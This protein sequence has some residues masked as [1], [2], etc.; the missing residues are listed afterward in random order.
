MKAL[1]KT[2]LLAAVGVALAVSILTGLYPENCSSC[3]I[4]SLLVSSISFS[5]AGMAFYSVLALLILL[6]RTWPAVLPML[7]FAAG[8]HG[9]LLFTLYENEH[10]CWLCVAAGASIGAAF[11]FQALRQPEE[12]TVMVLWLAIGLVT[13]KGVIEAGEFYDEQQKSAAIHTATQDAKAHVEMVKGKASMVIY[14]L[15]GCHNCERFETE[16]LPRIQAEFG[17]SV[18]LQHRDPPPYLPA[19]SIFIFPGPSLFL[20][21]PPQDEL[22][23]TLQEAVQASRTTESG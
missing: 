14:S 3:L 21:L 2:V 11:V 13:S 16:Q 18:T 23:E 22:K 10:T 17:D 9:V 7:A 8:V 1:D 19:P 6:P 4:A 20:G 15:P 5:W 12:R